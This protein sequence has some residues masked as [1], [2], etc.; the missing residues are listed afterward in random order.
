MQEWS[1]VLANQV[2]IAQ[3]RKKPEQSSSNHGRSDEEDVTVE[4]FDFLQVIGQG[5]FGKVCCA[6]LRFILSLIAYFMY[7]F[8]ASS[9]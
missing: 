2:D 7:C 9:F 4:T 6:F 5:S 1:H 8:I 3:G